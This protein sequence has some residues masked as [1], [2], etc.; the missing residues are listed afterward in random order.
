MAIGGTAVREPSREFG[1]GRRPRSTYSFS[2]PDLT[3]FLWAKIERTPNITMTVTRYPAT[4]ISTV[5]MIILLFPLLAGRLVDSPDDQR[6][7]SR[8]YDLVYEYFPNPIHD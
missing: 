1:F 5:A 2:S 4:K 3:C 6:Q 8:D 7:R